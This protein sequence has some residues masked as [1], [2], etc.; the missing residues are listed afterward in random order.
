MFGGDG[1][2]DLYGGSGNDQLEGG[3]GD[4]LLDGGS[5]TDQLN[6][7]T[8]ND[9]LVVE[10]QH[11]LALEQSWGQAGGGWDTLQVAE[12]FSS[13]P[14]TFV[15]GQ[16]FRRAG[17]RNVGRTSSGPR[18][19]R[20]PDADGLGRARCARRRPRQPPAGNAGANALYGFAGDD[21]LQG[22]DGDDLLDGGVGADRLEGGAG[23]DLLQ[24][25]TATIRCG[26]ATATTASPADAG[27]DLLYGGAGDDIYV[28]GLND[29]AIN[30]V[31][32][33]EGSN[34]VVLEGY[35]GQ[36]IQAAVLDG[37][38]H[39]VADANPVAIVSDYVGHEA[40]FAGIDF[41]AGIVAVEDLL[42]SSACG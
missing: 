25:A 5:G 18:R 3:D 33:H 32:D 42:A 40:S 35:T 19:D 22:G 6:G 38:L 31:F 10:H 29:Y 26:E 20:E 30:T 14:V 27:A 1:H 23:N 17:G 15:L 11:D 8:G 41:G 12:G 16:R 4:D 2:D 13:G 34:H 28:I 39:I 37:D 24:A 21:L 9:V 36:K 7:G